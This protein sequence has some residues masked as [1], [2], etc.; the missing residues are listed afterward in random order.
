[1]I[2]QGVED[3]HGSFAPEQVSLLFVVSN[4]AKIREE[5]RVSDFFRKKHAERCPRVTSSF[6]GF[7][8]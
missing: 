8:N 3:G 6:K 7:E 2:H 5:T 4:P 1:M